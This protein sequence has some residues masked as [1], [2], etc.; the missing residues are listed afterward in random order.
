MTKERRIGKDLQGSGPAR[1]YPRICLQRV[2]KRS[3]KLTQVCL[4]GFE[5]GSYGLRVYL[6]TCTPVPSVSEDEEDSGYARA[7][8]VGPKITAQLCVGTSSPESGS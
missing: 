1:H 7:I 6:I 3:Y 2:T 5:H 4:P 8:L